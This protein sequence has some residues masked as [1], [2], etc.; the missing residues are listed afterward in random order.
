MTTENKSTYAFKEVFSDK[1]LQVS[2]AINSETAEKF[3]VF[4]KDKK[5]RVE[6]SYGDY[7]VKRQSIWVAFA[8]FKQIVSVLNTTK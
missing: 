1:G 8:D 7:M 6:G 5:T 3:V 2:L 4:N